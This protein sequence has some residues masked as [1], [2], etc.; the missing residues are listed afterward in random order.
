[1]T[2]GTTLH[3]GVSRLLIGQISEHILELRG[4]TLHLASTHPMQQS[5]PNDLTSK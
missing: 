2:R 4:A 5:I 1:M 3:E